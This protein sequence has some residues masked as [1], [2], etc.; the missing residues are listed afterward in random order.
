[1]KKIFREMSERTQERFTEEGVTEEDIEAA[2]EWA[3]S[4]SET[5]N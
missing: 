3:R 2:I 1:M 4:A 5:E